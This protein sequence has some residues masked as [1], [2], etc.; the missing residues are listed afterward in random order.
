[1]EIFETFLFWALKWLWN[2]LI[3]VL[4]GFKPK[5]KSL[6]LTSSERKTLESGHY[7]YIYDSTVQGLVK[8]QRDIALHTVV[9]EDIELWSKNF[10]FVKSQHRGKH[11][12]ENYLGNGLAS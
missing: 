10:P 12:H 2:V 7:R 9:I 6:V 3:D 1:M 11:Y 4:V 5:M 8:K